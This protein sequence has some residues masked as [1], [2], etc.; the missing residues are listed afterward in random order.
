MNNVTNFNKDIIQDIIKDLAITT[1][2]IRDGVLIGYNEQYNKESK[3]VLDV[4]P[5]T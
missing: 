2:G 3:V 1:P 5:I 4:S